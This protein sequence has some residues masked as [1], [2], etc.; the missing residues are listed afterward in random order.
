MDRASIDAVVERFRPRGFFAGMTVDQVVAGGD[1]WIGPLLGLELVDGD[2][3]GFAELHVLAMDR[4]RV[5]RLDSWELLFDEAA[6]KKN[7]STYCRDYGEVVAGVAR[8]AAY[9]VK[10]EL[11]SV[12]P[13]LVARV[14]GAER[15]IAFRRDLKAFSVAF[16]DGMNRALAG[17][18]H[19]LVFVTN[20][21]CQG[22]L[23]VLPD[24]ERARLG[25]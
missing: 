18:G 4:S 16:V 10:I 12:R 25:W 20:D 1:E 21:Y 23:V 24:G 3:P 5:W 8:I 6:A 7:G 22:F 14:H 11:V 19:E 13:K 2:P 9:A 17:T 15:P